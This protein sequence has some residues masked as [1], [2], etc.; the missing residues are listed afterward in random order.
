MFV[1]VLKPVNYFSNDLS[2]CNDELAI[3]QKNIWAFL[4]WSENIVSNLLQKNFFAFWALKHEIIIR[5]KKQ[6]PR[7]HHGPEKMS[8]GL[9]NSNELHNNY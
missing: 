2:N 7:K 9:D 6:Q 5:N 4:S 8:I 1:T 3:E